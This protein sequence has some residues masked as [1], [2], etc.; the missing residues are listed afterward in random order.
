MACRLCAGASCATW[1]LWKGFHREV[2]DLSEGHESLA[3]DFTSKVLPWTCSSHI[4]GLAQPQAKRTK[5]L[6]VLTENTT[7]GICN[8]NL[9]PY[10]S[11]YTQPSVFLQ[12]LL[13]CAQPLAPNPLGTEQIFTLVPLPWRTFGS[14]NKNFGWG[15]Q[16]ATTPAPQLHTGREGV[17]SVHWVISSQRLPG[18]WAVCSWQRE[19]S[20]EKGKIFHCHRWGQQQASGSVLRGFLLSG[21]QFFKAWPH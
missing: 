5:A 13:P 14:A 6:F 17:A 19:K 8:I 9:L 2:S 12:R 16:R 21:R 3:L 18:S 1:C 20:G 7:L 4:K 11:I 15:W 10:L